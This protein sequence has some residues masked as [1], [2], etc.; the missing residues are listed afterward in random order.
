MSSVE[1]LLKETKSIF[2]K[3]ITRASIEHNELTIEVKIDDLL[4]TL[5]T[6]KQH[7]AFQFVQLID[8][9]GVDYKDYGEGTWTKSRF[10]VV[11]HFL[12][13]EHNHRIRVRTFSKEEDFPLFPSIIDLWPA[14]NW[15]EREAFDLF[16]FMFTDHPD[17]RRILTDYGF[18]GYPFRKDFPMIGKVEVRYDDVQKRVIYQ[19][20]SIDE[21]NNVPRIIREEG[22]HNG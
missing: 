3:E 7:K 11:Y 20:V 14:A 1:T 5:K 6:L 9:C 13:I 10:A 2:G 16:G 19:P 22:F 15:Y 17:L 21:R 4:T 8:L 12:S 18:V